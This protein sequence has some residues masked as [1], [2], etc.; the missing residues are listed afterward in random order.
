[1]LLWPDRTRF[2]LDHLFIIDFWYMGLLALPLFLGYHLKRYRVTISAVGIAV[3]LAYHAFVAYAHHQALLIAIQDRPTAQALA[4]PEALSPL[5]WSVFNRQDGVLRY[6]H[7]DFMK[8]S[9]PLVWTEWKEPL[10]TP[11]LRAAFND[12]EVRSFLWFARIPMWEVKKQVD[13]STV[14]DFWEERY[15]AVFGKLGSSNARRF[16]ASV[17]VRDGKV[18]EPKPSPVHVL[19]K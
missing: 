8:R 5:R 18:V 14:V 1:M 17:V 15:R 11:E 4:L 12:P 6:S 19:D 16:G 3:V 10:V 9:A 2:A 13:G 7:L